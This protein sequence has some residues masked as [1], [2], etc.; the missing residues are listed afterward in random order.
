MLKLML[1]VYPDITTTNIPIIQRRI[2]PSERATTTALR[3]FQSF[4]LMRQ[5]LE[6]DRQLKADDIEKMKQMPPIVKKLC[7]SATDPNEDCFALTLDVDPP[8]TRVRA[9]PR[10]AID[11]ISG[12]MGIRPSLVIKSKD[13]NEALE[14]YEA[15]FGAEIITPLEKKRKREEIVTTQ[16]ELK[17]GGLTYAIFND[18]MS[19]GFTSYRPHFSLLTDDFAGAVDKALKAGACLS[20]KVVQVYG[21]CR[22][23]CKLVKV[24]DPYGLVCAQALRRS[25][26]NCTRAGRTQASG[27]GGG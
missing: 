23:W 9:T 18:G 10:T 17:I 26:R 22:M 21:K 11:S 2:M 19:E 25:S 4:K 13:F 14:F 5:R 27:R 7:P 15:A 16:A 1:R 8:V 6:R 20:G 24:D 12:C 3:R